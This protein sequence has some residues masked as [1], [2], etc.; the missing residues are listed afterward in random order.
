MNEKV[1]LHRR[2]WLQAAGVGAALAA[3]PAF[4]IILKK[5][6]FK[7]QGREA[8]SAFSP[9]VEIELLAHVAKVPILPGPRT[10]VWHYKGRV[11]KGDPGSFIK[12]PDNYIG[13]ILKFRTGQRLRIYLHNKLPQNHIV[14]WHGMHV[15][16]EADGHP[17]YEVG[18]GGTYVYEFEVRNRASTNW[19]HPHTHLATAAQAYAGLAGLIIVEDE[20]EQALPLPRG[21]Y[22]L[23]LVLQDRT[24]T[25]DNQLLYDQR[26]PLSVLGFLGER[27]V[28]NGK[29]DLS[30][31]VAD[32]SYR[33]RVLNGSNA[34][35]FK[36]AWSD[37]EPVTVIGTD[38]G[39]LE[40]PVTR[41]YLMISPGERYELWRD[42]RNARGKEV[43]LLSEE[44]SGTMPPPYERY[45][46]SMDMRQMMREMMGNSGMGG[47]RGMGMMGN[48]G[49][50]MGPMAILSRHLPQGSR[51][52][53]VRFRVSRKAKE[54]TP[55]P[56]RLRSLPRY[57]VEETVNP[58]KPVPIA[59]GN[60]GMRFT[61]NGE[62]FDMTGALPS[63]TMAVNTWQLVEIFHAHGDM[64]REGGGGGMHG[65][66]DMDLSMNLAMAHPMHLHGA[67]FQIVERIP[68]HQ[69]GEHVGEGYETVKDGF[70]DEGFQETV[71]LMPGE[72]IRLVK[73]FPDYKG[74]F[75]YH[76]HNLEHENAG[77]MRNFKVI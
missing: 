47:R 72:R 54:N 68:P 74:L 75:L 11:L 36:L 67:Y 46:R 8:S 12:L 70:V 76:C 59:I 4:P 58:G 10:Q 25:V 64:N 56:D 22:D 27:I 20:E 37:G 61:L 26:G 15:P 39:L 31:D 66:S 35:I 42:F 69:G 73:P 33:F 45:L 30:M 50:G 3:T 18:P 17:S 49:G 14:H 13:P 60:R 34:R 71:L 16:F 51:L 7:Q 55:L 21:E 1:D 53:L 38:G 5:E 41:P 52:E 77:M 29:P 23:P 63:E 48:M 44:F 62:L 32:R 28:V 19:F 65:M 2:R 57:R 6:A 9:D 24:F 40:K 43:V